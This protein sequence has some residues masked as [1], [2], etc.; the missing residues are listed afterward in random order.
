MKI[1]KENFKSPSAL[2]CFFL[3]CALGLSLDLYTKWYAFQALAPHAAGVQ[4][5]RPRIVRFIPNWVHFEITTNRGAVFG[6]GQGQK[7][8]F[9]AVSVLALIALLYLFANSRRQRFY[10]FILGMLLAGVL[11]NA[12]DRLVFGHVRDMIHALP[13]WTWPGTWQAPLL[14]YPGHGRE[15][16][17]FIF[18]VADILLCVGVGLMIVY[19]LFAAPEKQK[20]ASKEDQPHAAPVT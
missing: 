3:T 14:N 10:Q 19:S 18:N 1:P 13:G 15:V 7:A 9:L 20:A 5:D 17:P 12:Y 2:A 8:L 4:D 6:L 16:F 11:G